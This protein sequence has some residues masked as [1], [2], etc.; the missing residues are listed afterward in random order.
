VL[1]T[2]P[3]Q[4]VAWLIE[5][6]TYS[7][8]HDDQLKAYRTWFENE[9]KLEGYTP[10]YIYLTRYADP[11]KSDPCWQPVGYDSVI[12]ILMARPQ[13]ESAA[14]AF[15]SDYVDAMQRWFALGAKSQEQ[16]MAVLSRLDWSLSGF[17]PGQLEGFKDEYESL[18]RLLKRIEEARA[19][20]VARPAT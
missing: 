7:G 11:P 15:I 6:K 17:P 12:E 4:Q 3:K 14:D 9:D 8:E 13:R 19:R 16:G 20:A 2:L 1:A 10:H 5:L 18:R